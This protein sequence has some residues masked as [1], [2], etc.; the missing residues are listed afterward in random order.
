[1]LLTPFVSGLLGW[2][3]GEGLLLANA[4]VGFHLTSEQGHLKKYSYEIF[5][6]LTI[7]FPGEPEQR[8]LG[9]QEGG[10]TEQPKPQKLPPPLPSRA[11]A[12]VARTF[13]NRVTDTSILLF[14]FP[15]RFMPLRSAFRVWQMI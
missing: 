13:A 6:N 4:Q 7:Y 10:Q 5:L 11:L 9:G 15:A 3:R 8:L 14:A 12:R 1:M 2:R